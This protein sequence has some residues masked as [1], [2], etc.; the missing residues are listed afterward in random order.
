[1]SV[2]FS[3]ENIEGM[4]LTNEKIVR[5]RGEGFEVDREI[6]EKLFARLVAF[7]SIEDP[8]LR[9]ITIAANLLARITFDQP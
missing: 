4:I 6:L 9:I 8:R 1:M 5:E 3:A 2:S 7:H